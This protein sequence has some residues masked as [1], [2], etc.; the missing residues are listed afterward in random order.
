MYQHVSGIQKG[1]SGRILKLVTK[2]IERETKSG[3]IKVGV[4]GFAFVCF[5]VYV[6]FDTG[7]AGAVQEEKQEES[8]LLRS[9]IHFSP[10]ERCVPFSD[11]GG[12][13][14]IGGIGVI[15]KLRGL[16]WYL[17]ELGF[18]CVDLLLKSAREPR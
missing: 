3:E 15:R 8:A 4:L 12:L 6:Q 10:C 5:D 11:E 1:P 13:I 14:F 17:L 16:S 7:S 2:K 18:A 9:T